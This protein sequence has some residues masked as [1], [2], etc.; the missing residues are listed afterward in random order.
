[1]TDYVFLP[2]SPE[3]EKLPEEFEAINVPKEC[4]LEQSLKREVEEIIG[5]ESHINRIV[6]DSKDPNPHTAVRV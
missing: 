5:A 6:Y 2:C 3:F 4:I 1:M